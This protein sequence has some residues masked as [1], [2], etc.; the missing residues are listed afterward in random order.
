MIKTTLARVRSTK[1]NKDD[2]PLVVHLVVKQNFM[3]LFAQK[4]RKANE[5]PKK[6]QQTLAW[7]LSNMVM[8]YDHKGSRACW[9]Y[10]FTHGTSNETQARRHPTKFTMQSKPYYRTKINR[11]SHEHHH[12]VNIRKAQSSK[13]K[14]TN[15]FFSGFAI[16]FLRIGR[17]HI[18]YSFIY[19]TNEKKNQAN[20][21]E[22]DKKK[23]SWVISNKIET[24]MFYGTSSTYKTS[25]AL[26]L[27]LFP[28]GH[29]EPS[30][31][32]HMMDENIDKERGFHLSTTIGSEAAIALWDK[33]AKSMTKGFKETTSSKGY[34]FWGKAKAKNSG[35][36]HV[37]DTNNYTVEAHDF[38]NWTKTIYGT[39]HH[40]QKHSTHTEK[41][42]K[43]EW[44]INLS[45]CEHGHAFANTHGNSIDFLTTRT[46]RRKQED[47]K[48]KLESMRTDKRRA[49]W[50]TEDIGDE[51]NHSEAF[52]TSDFIG[53]VFGHFYS[54]QTNERHLFTGKKV[55][56]EYERRNKQ[57]S[58]WKENRKKKNY[59]PILLHLLPHLPLLAL[60]HPPR[61]WSP[62]VWATRFSMRF[63]DEKQLLRMKRKERRLMRQ[64]TKKL[65]Q[66]PT[67][68]GRVLEHW[69][70]L[71]PNQFVSIMPIIEFC[72][73]RCYSY[74][75]V[76]RLAER[77]RNFC[78]LWFPK[79]PMKIVWHLH[80]IHR[81]EP[82]IKSSE[83]NKNT[84]SLS[85]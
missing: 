13:E 60:L 46:H 2:C 23:S 55:Q 9:V 29:E 34:H 37:C 68:L 16:I 49:K 38:S 18:F 58:K 79:S 80:S 12:K 22:T 69:Y 10:S 74:A 71:S 41:W 30:N 21:S 44:T 72:T 40:S 59:L 64:K 78:H 76:T 85:S 4:K 7:K 50:N 84:F 45:N 47:A 83:L 6:H 35:V 19:S 63:Y 27:A 17:P 42:L 14:S 52:L 65:K 8:K 26:R 77:L 39:T 5:K 82:V 54:S 67:I 1:V 32:T 73:P 25:S 57:K 61:P 56:D 3:G 48:W 62:F 15:H 70:T 81:T 28:N 36:R 75:W 11:L 20:T 66:R 51:L 31:K 53:D 43:K 24:K 33:T